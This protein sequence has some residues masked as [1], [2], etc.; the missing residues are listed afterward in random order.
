MRGEGVRR[1]VEAFA[2]AK[3]TVYMYTAAYYT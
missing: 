3:G 2:I 1:G